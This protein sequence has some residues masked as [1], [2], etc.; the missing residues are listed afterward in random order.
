MKVNIRESLGKL[1]LETDNKY[2]LRNTYDGSNISNDK[3][4]MLAESISKNASAKD[5][6]S[7]LNED[8]EDNDFDPQYDA[9]YEVN[10]WPSTVKV[11]QSNT[12]IVPAIRSAFAASRTSWVPGAAAAPK[13]VN[14]TEPFAKVP[15]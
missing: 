1:D 7:I 6:Y 3:K 4:K 8:F 14:W 15:Q 5:I 11:E 13:E 9:R 12:L 10:A 2:D